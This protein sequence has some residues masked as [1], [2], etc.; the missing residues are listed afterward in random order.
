MKRR[1]G[2]NPTEKFKARVALFAVRSWGLAEPET[3]F[4]IPS[5]PDSGWGNLASAPWLAPI[6]RS[7]TD[8]R[9]LASSEESVG[10]LWFRELPK[11]V[12]QREFCHSEGPEPV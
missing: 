1:P 10:E 8:V 9:I 4:D 6:D 7:R 12:I 2:P 5:Q 3:Q 11:Y